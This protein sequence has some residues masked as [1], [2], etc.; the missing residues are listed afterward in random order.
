MTTKERIELAEL[1][2]LTLV[3]W[4][5]SVPE[6]MGTKESFRLFDESEDKINLE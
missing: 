1:C 4:T 5:E 3:G 2:G 6:F